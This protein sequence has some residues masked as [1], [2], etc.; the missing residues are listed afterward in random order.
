MQALRHTVGFLTCA[1]VALLISTP[2]TAGEKGQ[3]A[4]MVITDVRFTDLNDP[5]LIE[6]VGNQ[7]DNGGAPVVTLDGN[8]INVTGS[9][10]TLIQA[11]LPGNTPHGDYVI[12][13]ST[14]SGNKQSAEQVLTVAPLVAMSVS[15]ID[16]FITAGHEEHIH[17]ELHV[18][19]TSGDA[20]LGAIVTY[21]N[22]ANGIVW[23]TNVST[24]S[25]TAGKAKGATCSD[26]QGEGVTG[27]FCCIGAH[28]PDGSL[29]GKRSCPGGEYKATLLSVE[30]PPGTALVW[31]GVTPPNDTVF[32][33]P[34]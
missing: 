22:A 16:W 34:N 5:S 12:G 24:T 17:N 30:P 4:P 11:E 7:F 32:F 26:P 1:I 25:K 28:E 8:A 18:V 27:W 31:D 33:E 19:D 21:T 23:Q 9:S 10:A 2:A 3:D 15:C 13:V 6:V 14:G 29:P 20:V